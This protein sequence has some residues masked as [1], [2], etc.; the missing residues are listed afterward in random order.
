[1]PSSFLPSIFPSIRD[2]SNELSVHIRWPK[3]WNFSF[4]ISSSSEYSR[5][6][7]L[8]LDWFDLLAVQGTFRSLLQHHSSKASILWCSAVFMVQFSQPYMTT[9]KTT[10]LTIWTFVGRVMSLFFNTLSWFVIPLH[11]SLPCYGKGAYVTQRSYEPCHAGP[12]KKHSHGKEFWQNMIHWRRES[13]ITPGYLSWE[14]HELYKRPKKYAIKC[15]CTFRSVDLCPN[16]IYIWCENQVVKT[17]FKSISDDSNLKQ[18]WEPEIKSFHQICF[19]SQFL[20]SLHPG[21]QAIKLGSI[22]YFFPPSLTILIQ[23]NMR[24]CLL[25]S[26]WFCSFLTMPLKLNYVD[27]KLRDLKPDK[28]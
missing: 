13:H 12:S 16:D 21:T 7:S 5:L 25:N 1:M 9:G 6:I 18:F 27:E 14:P 28:S 20:F 26:T 10:A 24:I 17:D 15:H 22:L 3:Y 19:H 4:S 11:V 23:S 2:F 8:K